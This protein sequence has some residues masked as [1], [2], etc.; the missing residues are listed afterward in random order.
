MKE[1]IEDLKQL[2]K[3]D[4]WKLKKKLTYFSSFV[5]LWTVFVYLIGG[6]WLYFIPFII[7]DVIFWKTFNYT[8]WK[9]RK[10]EERKP[11]S[12]FRSWADAI[13][14]AVIAA[15]L[16]RTFFIEAYT[17]PT[18]SMEKS[19]MVGDYLFVSKLSYGPRVPMTPLAFPLV[20]HTLPL[21][22]GKSY[23]EWLSLPY[24][25]MAGLSKVE[26][27]DCVVFNWPAE[28]LF[29]IEDRNGNIINVFDS[30]K[31][32]IDWISTQP[33]K[34]QYKII[35]GEF[36]RPIDKKENYIKRCVA[37]PGDEIKIENGELSINGIEEVSYNWMKKQRRYFVKIK[38]KVISNYFKSWQE[39]SDYC[40]EEYDIIPINKSTDFIVTSEWKIQ[41]TA[42]QFAIS[43]LN[44]KEYIESIWYAGSTGGIFDNPQLNPDYF[45]VHNPYG[46][47][48]ENY[49]P[50]TIPKQG[51][52]VTLTSENLA[53]YKQVISRYEGV[54]M[55]DPEKFQNIKTEIDA[56]GS[57]SYTFKQNYYW[58]MGD[59]R[60]NSADSRFWGFVPENHIVGKSLFIW[61][62]YDKYGKGIR[63][64]RFRGVQIVVGIILLLFLLSYGY[65]LSKIDRNEWWKRLKSDL[66]YLSLISF[67]IKIL[68]WLFF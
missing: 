40:Y 20:H 18:P 30:R 28:R 17:I 54:E 25:R 22:G 14:F 50:L 61:M 2:H 67:S 39:F 13:L 5:I 10:K 35:E 23:S 16:L 49:G 21:V 15:T 48:E 27:N 33:N 29:P 1:I 34:N 12:S 66:I 63:W 9:K 7:G 64:E 62:S 46:W 38:P 53:L 8:F 55:E 51:T 57:A 4:E 3:I 45:L 68:Q 42:T 43:E 56:N 41:I 6:E 52:T 65:K 60:Q 19:L 59:N 44:K 37:L 11:K 36:S 32:S 47:N 31:K 58:L 24:Y 26:R